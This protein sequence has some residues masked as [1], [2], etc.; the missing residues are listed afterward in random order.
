M[1]KSDTR[2]LVGVVHL[3]PLPGAPGYAGDRR[4]IV[5][6]ALADAQAFAE[7]GASGLI[8]E[9]F[10]DA[11]F[12][13]GRVGAEVVAE[14]T[15]VAR[16]VGVLGLPFGINVLRNDGLSALAIAAASGAS[17]IRVNILVGARVADQGLIEGVAH[18]LLR[19]RRSIGAESVAVWA[20][21]DVKHSVPLGAYD[22]AREAADAVLR[23][24]AE[25]LIVTGS[26]TGSAAASQTLT[27]VRSAVQN[28]PILVGSGV[29]EANVG[30]FAQADGFIVGS[31]LKQDGGVDQ[32]VS[33]ARVQALVKAIDCL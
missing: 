9:N 24:G 19:Y 11:P 8:L 2:P 28:V 32:P 14:M 3:K 27:R 30:Q 10:A 18:D 26:S 1:F 4:A 33:T 7:G 25:A 22:V 15:A 6:A 29:D 23:G 20:D 17:F 21:V 31:S 12:T 5:D 16:C 13:A